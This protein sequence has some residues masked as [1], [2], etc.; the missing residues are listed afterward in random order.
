MNS[1][2]SRRIRPRTRAARPPARAARRLGATA[3]LALTAALA[4][5]LASGCSGD[6]NADSGQSHPGGTRAPQPAALS[7]GACQLL[8]Y[9]VVEA[10]IG[11]RFAIAASA[12]SAAT[13]TCVLQPD[14]ADLPDLSLAV[15]AT[16]ADM[17]VFRT[18]VV[19]K[20]GTTIED[21]GKLGYRVGVPASA[22]A[23]PGVEVGWLSANQRLMVLRYRSATGTAQGDVDAL[24][25]KLVD[26]AKKIDL[27][28]S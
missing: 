22:T 11:V 12:T 8:D 2:S 23:G 25:P 16:E 19:P 1:P 10:A 20:G 4:T 5:G 7:G 26:L 15:T 27:T 28:T 3:V 14:G 17:S 6:A 13:F 24:A 9:D 21:L 18:S